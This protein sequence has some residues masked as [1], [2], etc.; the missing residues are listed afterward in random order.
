MQTFVFLLVLFAA[1]THASWNFFSK[2][3]SGNFTLFWFG[4]AGANILLIPFSV[5]FIY[6]SGFS[7]AAAVFIFISAAAHSLYYWTLL[8][9]Y[10]KGDISTAYPIARGIGVAG[11]A[12]ISVLFLKETVSLNGG[13]GIGAIL[14][15]VF[16]IGISRIPGQKFHKKSYY[17]AI[18][19][20]CFI[21]IYSLADNKGA[22]ICHP[23]V[24]IN[25]LDL[26]CASVLAPFAFPEG[27]KKSLK[28]LRNNLRD[29]IIIG[30]GSSGTYILILFAFTFEKAS[31]IVALRESSVVIGS[32]MGFIFLKEKP[33]PYK[34]A[35]ILF[36]TA[37]LFLLKLS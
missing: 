14:A 5:F 30:L 20:G 2:K 12:L 37:G 11:T 15:G 22:N 25:I 19:T 24:Y 35:G 29:T 21:F 1:F 16:L 8:Y 23:V 4:L 9:S 33:T 18:I 34:V 32:V 28:M 27:M 10:K 7:S 17:F 31:Y 36:I 26:I 13:L 3:I 6:R